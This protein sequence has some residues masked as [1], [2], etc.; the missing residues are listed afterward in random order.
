M[1]DAGGV[2]G[3]RVGV[4]NVNEV[5]DLDKD[6]SVEL[7]GMG[8]GDGPWEG[9]VGDLREVGAADGPDYLAYGELGMAA[10]P[11]GANVAETVLGFE[12]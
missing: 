5:L 2:G 8:G 3:A 6:F 7:D 12:G 10:E 9:A 1:E 11:G 4:G